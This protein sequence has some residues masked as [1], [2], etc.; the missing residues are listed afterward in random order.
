MWIRKRS[1]A[2]WS[3][4]VRLILIAAAIVTA[5]PAHAQEASLTGTI[6]DAT[7]G[8]LPGVTV[9]ALHTGTGNTFVGVTDEAG[10]FRLPVRVGDYRLSA[11]LSGF[12]TVARTIS[13]LV[14]QTALVNL[15][16]STAGLEESVTVSGQ[17]PLVD[18]TT[19]SVG[20]AIDSRQVSDLPVNGRNWVDLAMLAPGSRLNASTDEPGTLVGTVG[21]GTFQLNVDG[22]RVTQNQTSGFGQPK[23]SKD[24]I[25]EFEFVSSRFDATQGGSMGVQ[26]NA[27]T[28]SGTNNLAGSFASYFRDDSLVGK[29]FVQDRVLPYS[30]QQFSWTLGGP[31]RRDRM[32]FFA[33][34]E[35]ERQPQTISY[36][37]RV[38]NLQHR[39]DRHDHR[40]EGR[41]APGSSVLAEESAERARQWLGALGALRRPL[42]RRRVQ[43]PFVG[44]S[45]HETQQRSRHHADAGAR[46]EH[47]QRDPGR[48]CGVLLDPRFENPM[49]ESPLWAAD[50]DADSSDAQLYDWAGARLHARVRRCRELH[51]QGQPDVFTQQVWPS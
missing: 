39:S 24:A 51:D 7:G 13:L 21:V 43:A 48:I 42:H 34:Y 35:Y 3:A 38:S 19:S 36:I 28:K 37:E 31:I 45:E 14:G 50:R 4:L 12:A 11:E 27:I 18:A 17:A 29:D 49:V 30:D 20:K 9:T 8:V 6:T 1:A 2:R 16:M 44:D 22:L 25:A 40:K 47:V 46:H 26:V 32:H 23:Y 10:V 33:N 5:M 41:R 15:Q